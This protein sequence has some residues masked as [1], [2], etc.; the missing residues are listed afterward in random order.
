MEIID[1]L[2]YLLCHTL[3]AS[4]KQII[5]LFG[6]LFLIG[7]ALYGISRLRNKV[8]AESV[9]SK[10][11]LFLTGWIGIPVHEAGHALFCLI[12]RHKITEIKFFSPQE[13]GT[14]GY[15]KHEFNSKNFYQK[16]GNFFI[17]IAPMLFG[18]AMIYALL[19]IFLPE[20]LPKELGEGIGITGLEILK[21]ILNSDNLGSWRFWVF[22]YLSLCVASH[23]TLS[24]QDF[25]GAVPSFLIMLFLIFLVNLVANIFLSNGLGSVSFTNWFSEKTDILL[26]F[27]YSVMIYA[28]AV[29]IIYLIFSYL[30]FLISKPFKR[31]S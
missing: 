29:S 6:P 17:G 5:W 25:K 4:F 15:V 30:L 26:S 18:A 27:F 1:K 21:N 23:A 13:D 19:W 3:I 8:L 28:L 14:M 2:Y 16:I 9:G 10:A 24:V 7:F 20:C 12:F 11:V 31:K 22:F